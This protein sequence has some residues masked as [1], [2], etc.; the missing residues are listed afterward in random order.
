MPTNYTEH[1]ALSQWEPGD[2]VQRTD[3]NADNAKIDAA[4]KAE[5]DARAA[6]DAAHAAALSKLGNCKLCI[7]SYVGDGFWGV[8]HKMTLTFPKVPELLLIFGNNAFFRLVPLKEGQAVVLWDNT[9]WFLNVTWNGSTASWYSTSG[10]NGQMNH[11]D[12]T[13]RVLAFYET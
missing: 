2:K 12:A 9:R 4:I 8:D 3:F 5:A 1:Y 10:G 13:Y 6:A 11:S 7:S